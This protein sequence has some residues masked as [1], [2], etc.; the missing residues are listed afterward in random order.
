MKNKTEWGDSKSKRSD[1]YLLVKALLHA[2][3]VNTIEKLKYLREVEKLNHLK[4]T[5]IV[6]WITNV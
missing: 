2:H 6:S 1:S 5:A 3:K 4:K